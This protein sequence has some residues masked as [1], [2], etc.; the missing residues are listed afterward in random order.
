MTQTETR[1]GRAGGATPGTWGPAFGGRYDVRERLGAGGPATTYR[2]FDLH[3]G[4]EVRLKVVTTTQELD[5]PSL[6]RLGRD[7]E[8]V[9]ALDHPNVVAIL[10]YGIAPPFTPGVRWNRGPAHAFGL[11]DHNAPYVA[12]ELI[13]GQPGRGPIPAPPPA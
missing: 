8:A 13:P 1:K 5:G 9:A 3:L 2:A 6:A 12:T 7:L 10:D 4:R 11:P